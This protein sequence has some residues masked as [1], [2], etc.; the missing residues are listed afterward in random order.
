MNLAE[1]ALEFSKQ[2]LKPGGSFLIKVFQGE[3]FDEYLKL[4]RANFDKVKTRKPKASRDRSK[5]LY[6][7]VKHM[8]PQEITWSNLR[9]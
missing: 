5:E 7:L 3:G 8:T 1:S 2:V 6:L 9:L 4:L